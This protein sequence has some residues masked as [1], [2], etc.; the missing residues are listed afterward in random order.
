MRLEDLHVGLPV[1]I[2]KDHP[3]GYGGRVGNVV[4]VGEAKTLDNKEVIKGATVD[5]GEV[6]LVMVEAD[7]LEQVSEE[8]LPPGWAEFDV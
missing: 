3:S 2:A 4:A 5:I 1:R 8:E 6:L 7:S